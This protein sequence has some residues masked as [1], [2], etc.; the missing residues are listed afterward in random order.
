MRWLFL[1]VLVLNFAYV[2][3]ELSRPEEIVSIPLANRNAPKI[4]L[5]SEIG[6]DSVAEVIYES[7]AAPESSQGA[8]ESIVVKRQCFTLGPFRDL[9][10]LRAVTRGIK[11]YVVDASFRSHDE[12]EQ[13][14]FWVY[15]KPA[16]DY[17]KAK[18][19]ADRL[20]S[21]NVK[22]YFIVKKEP[23]LNAIS[24]GHFREKNRAYDHAAS[25]AKLGFKPEVEALFKDYTIYWLDYEVAL[26]EIIPEITF[27]KYLSGKIN[28]LVRDCS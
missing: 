15:L 12:K 11:K 17:D 24:L 1:F 19:L 8:D 28:R 6:K 13:A 7:E 22:D 18:V 14:M 20:K 25:M 3:W 16:G 2:A 26:G 5:L 4:I 21:K 10:K 23:K 27:E 9:E